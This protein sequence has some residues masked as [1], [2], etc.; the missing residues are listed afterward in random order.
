MK[1]LISLAWFVAMAALPFSDRAQAQRAEYNAMVTKHA[2]ANAVP[3]ALVHRVIVRESRYQPALV[4]HGGTIGLMQIKLATARG[5]GY[6]GDAEGLR[7]PETNLLYGVKYL[8]GA[9]RVANGNHDRAVAYYASGYYEAA[10]RWRI[11]HAR[12]PEPMLASAPPRDAV[13]SADVAKP[14]EAKPSEAKPEGSKPENEARPEE[15]AATL[16]DR[17]K[18]LEAT[19]LEAA[20]AAPQDNPKPQIAVAKPKKQ[21]HKKLAEAK[22]LVPR[23]PA[24]IPTGANTA[25]PR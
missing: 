6:T 13:K 1:R 18:P 12:H 5:L 8:A 2:K 21:I 17:V 3:E 15:A 22:E 25:K 10:K 4:G 20:A 23:P 9:Y 7:D 11:E 19:Q 14:T 24:R 16:E